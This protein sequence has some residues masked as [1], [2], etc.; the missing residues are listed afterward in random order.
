ML[1]ASTTPFSS[2]VSAPERPPSA[3][4]CTSS[5]FSPACSN[6]STAVISPSDFGLLMANFLPLRSLTVLIGEFGITITTLSA[7]E[8]EPRLTILIFS[9]CSMAA[10]AGAGDT[11][12]K[13]RSLA[14]ALRT[15]VPPPAPEITP[16][17]SIPAFL[18]KPLSMAT[19]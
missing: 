16:V 10:I 19:P 15:E 11:S 2:A 12:P 1:V 3:T 6:T 17:M 13:P 9:P 8:R 4:R 18:K 7:S 5:G 14:I